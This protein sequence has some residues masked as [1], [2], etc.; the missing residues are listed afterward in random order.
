MDS[1]LRAKS[2]K[3]EANSQNAEKL[4]QNDSSAN[5]GTPRLGASSAT[6]LLQLYIPG[7]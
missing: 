2:P 4:E 1:N 7:F 3:A 5:P 6:D